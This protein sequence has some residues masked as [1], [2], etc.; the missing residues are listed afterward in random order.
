MKN[1]NYILIGIGALVIGLLGGYFVSDDSRYEHM[2]GKF[3]FDRDGKEYKNESTDNSMM[4]DGHNMGDMMT[5]I[6]ERAFLEHMI[7]HHQEA[8]DTAKQVVA[9]GENTEVKALA[10]SIITAQEKEIADMK[11]WYK[12][13]YGAEYKNDNTYK[14]MMRDLSKLSGNALDKAFVEDMIQHHMGALMTNQQVVPNIEHN[15]IKDLA[16]AIA[17]TQSSE[18]VTMRILMSQL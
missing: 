9:R 13:W 18:I 5:G 4:H 12:N 3:G 8:V 16:T 15:E 1:N 10:A 6:S 7:P 2:R 11:S 17:E 14:P